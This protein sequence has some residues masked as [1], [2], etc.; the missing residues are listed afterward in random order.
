M[1]RKGHERTNLNTCL[2]ACLAP[3]SAALNHEA[4][5]LA[6][7]QPYSHHEAACL[8]AWPLTS[9]T[10]TMKLPACLPACLAPPQQPHT[11]RL[12]VCLPGPSASLNYEAVC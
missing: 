1:P 12:S 2:P 11:M 7:H 9:P 5:C 8:P 3:P 10:R 6:P 4:A